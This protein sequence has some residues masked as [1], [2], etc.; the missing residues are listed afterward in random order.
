MAE[1]GSQAGEHEEFKD[2][3]DDK[4]EEKVEIDSD[5]EEKS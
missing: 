5:I 2:S 3:D 1:E 4:D